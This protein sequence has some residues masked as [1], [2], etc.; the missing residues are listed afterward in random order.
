MAGAIWGPV[1]TKAALTKVPILEAAVYALIIKILW[2]GIA[3]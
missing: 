2:W 1:I 3:M